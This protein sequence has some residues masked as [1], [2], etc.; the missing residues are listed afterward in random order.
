MAETD[1]RE[2]LRGANIDG[3]TL[4]IDAV[5][6]RPQYVAVNKVLEAAGG[7]ELPTARSGNQ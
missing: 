2:I 7:N 4:S 3:N 6:T 5:L 1:V